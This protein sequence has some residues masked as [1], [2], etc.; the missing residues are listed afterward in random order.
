VAKPFRGSASAVFS[1]IK[2]FQ[3]EKLHENLYP[4]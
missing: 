1:S 3:R 2:S 4:Q